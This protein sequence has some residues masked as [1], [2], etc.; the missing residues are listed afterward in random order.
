MMAKNIGR[1][2]A[3]MRQE[4][5]MVGRARSERRVMRGPELG[6]GAAMRVR[7]A[8]GRTCLRREGGWCRRCGW[9]RIVE[10][11]Q[12]RKVEL[13]FCGGILL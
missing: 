5:E 4:P 10:R 3:Q 12:L 8:G 7:W 13:N 1:L 11:C 6:L 9:C 2:R